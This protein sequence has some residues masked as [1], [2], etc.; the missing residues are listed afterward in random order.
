MPVLFKKLSKRVVQSCKN[1]GSVV[2]LLQ[3]N[4]EKNHDFKE[5]SKGKKGAVLLQLEAFCPFN[6]CTK[7]CWVHKRSLRHFFSSRMKFA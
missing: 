5:I 3:G 6:W 2:A 4:F 7:F 1:L